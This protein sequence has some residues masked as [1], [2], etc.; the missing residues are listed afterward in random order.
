MKYFKIA[1]IVVFIV[2]IGLY[3]GAL[4]KEKAAQ[5]PNRP[6]ITSQKS[7]IEIPVDYTKE[8]LKEG[9]TAWDEEDGDLTDKILLGD[10]SQFIEK[11]VCNVSY[12]V[13][14]S[15]NQAATLTRKIRFTGYESPQFTLSS[16]LIFESGVA[17][18]ILG[19]I[20]ASDVL[21]GNISSMVKQTASDV[22]YQAPGAY[23]I[24][25][26][27][28]NSFGDV[29]N[30]ALPVHIVDSSIQLLSNN[31]PLIYLKKGTAFDVNTC[32]NQVTDA[33]GKAVNA[34]KIQVSSN[35]NINEEGV[36]EVQLTSETGMTWTTVIVRE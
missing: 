1:V 22:V 29:T 6:V 28:T 10:L 7:E 36:Y 21:D 16:P 14:D 3:A 11:G 5:D 2:G 34:A 19:K 20:G 24:H 9:L 12:I 26:E 32:K 25:V 8:Q 17:V 23:T 13:F 27:V 15:A 31:A 33:Q 35:V 4:A 30:A 18:D